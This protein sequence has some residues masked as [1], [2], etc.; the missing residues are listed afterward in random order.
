MQVNTIR[1]SDQLESGKKTI[2]VEQVQFFLKNAEV[3]FK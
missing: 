3:I 1:S 2:R